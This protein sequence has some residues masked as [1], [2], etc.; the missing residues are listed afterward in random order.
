[1]YATKYVTNA[2]FPSVFNGFFSPAKGVGRVKSVAEVQILSSAPRKAR[3][4]ITFSLAFLFFKA[5]LI[6]ISGANLHLPFFSFRASRGM[7]DWI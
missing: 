3:E 2:N 5:A 6:E 4:N 1:M 7:M